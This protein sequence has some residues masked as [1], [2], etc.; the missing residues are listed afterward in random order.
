L[1]IQERTGFR[2]GWTQLILDLVII[3]ISL[4][5]IPAPA[6]LLSAIGAVLLNLV[7][8]MNHRPGRYI[9]H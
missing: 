6:V 4:L 5:V 3:L 7:L 9:G 1:L 8:A 2:A